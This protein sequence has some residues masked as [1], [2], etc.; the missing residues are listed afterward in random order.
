[1]TRQGVREVHYLP[2]FSAC[3][4]M[5]PAFSDGDEGTGT[6]SSGGKMEIIKSK[7]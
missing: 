1:M 6:T 7:S 2:S 3:V 4:K 5:A